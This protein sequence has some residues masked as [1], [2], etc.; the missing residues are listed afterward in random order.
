RAG[1]GGEVALVGFD[2]VERAKAD[3]TAPVFARAWLQVY[4]TVEWKPSTPRIALGAAREIALGYAGDQLLV[5]TA[6]ATGRWTVG[7]PGVGG[8]GG[9]G[10]SG[11]AGG[12]G[13]VPRAGGA[14]R[15]PGTGVPREGGRVARGRGGVTGGGPGAPP[16]TST[17]KTPVGKPIQIR[18]SGE[19]SQ[20]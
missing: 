5:A 11:A 12:A 13:S 18:E 19:A 9:G 2:R 7:E 10:G 20:A 3:D 6:A 17:L 14:P 15:G 1:S 4:D 16:M 8:G